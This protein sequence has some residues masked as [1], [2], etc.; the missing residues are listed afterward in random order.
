MAL[1]FLVSIQCILY[2]IYIYAGSCPLLSDTAALTVLQYD[3]TTHNLITVLIQCINYEQHLIC[4]RITGVWSKESLVCTIQ[5]L[6]TGEWIYSMILYHWEQGI[7]PDI[8][9]D[10]TIPN[11]DICLFITE[12][13]CQEIL[14]GVEL[15]A[16]EASKILPGVTQL[17]IWDI[18]RAKRARYYYGWI[19]QNRVYVRCI[20]IFIPP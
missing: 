14:L 12:W 11:G 4:N 15:S 10:Y 16:S 17:K 18:Y 6:K 5:P 9:R 20:Y 2:I 13:L 8:F 7:K 3:I 19:M 1:K